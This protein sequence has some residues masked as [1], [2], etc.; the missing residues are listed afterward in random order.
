MS[1]AA[2]TRLGVY[3]I[4]GSLGTGGMGEVYR[5][6]DARLGREVAITY[7]EWTPDGRWLVFSSDR[8]GGR[9]VSPV[10]QTPFSEFN[11]ILSPDSRWLA[12]EADDSGHNEIYVR[13][14]PD[15]NSGRWQ[16]SAGAVRVRCGRA[17]AGNCSLC[18]PQAQS[19]A[20][21]SNADHRGRRQRRR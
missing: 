6:R 4:L 11:G 21:M 1:L 3:D 8:A 18:H 19:C 2:G 16:V 9:R 14:F 20:S 5:A 10:V 13:P 17:A 15:V 12:Y 7:P